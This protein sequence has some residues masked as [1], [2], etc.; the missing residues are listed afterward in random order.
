MSH[1]KYIIRQVP[2]LSG[3]EL[4]VSSPILRAD[5]ECVQSNSHYGAGLPQLHSSAHL[6][7]GGL[8]DCLLSDDMDFTGSQQLK[9]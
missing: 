6:Y 1:L 7:G 3:G 2:V 9:Q 4:K 5:P 8:Y